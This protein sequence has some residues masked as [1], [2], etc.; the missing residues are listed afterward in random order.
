MQWTI[1]PGR[2]I[3]WGASAP[4]VVHRG[5]HSTHAELRLASS[6]ACTPT[7]TVPVLLEAIK[8]TL[9]TAEA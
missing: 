4:V 9:T 6:Q 5:R 7:I 1:M 8:L 3:D 2:F